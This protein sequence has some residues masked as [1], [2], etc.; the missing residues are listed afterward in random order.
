[1]RAIM[2]IFVFA[3]ALWATPA[4]AAQRLAHATPFAA[5]PR[6]VA[7]IVVAQQRFEIMAV[8]RRARADTP[9]RRAHLHDSAAMS[10]VLPGYPRPAFV[11]FDIRFKF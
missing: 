8:T 5:K 10:K 2:T 11:S 1:M 6:A 4:A 3:L 9:L 7:A